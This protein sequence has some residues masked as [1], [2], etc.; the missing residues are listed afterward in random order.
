MPQAANLSINDGTAAVV[1]SPDSV[2]A[3]HVAYQNLAQP[4]LSLR[5]MAHLDRP[6]PTGNG[7]K[8]VRRSFRVNT[9]V[10]LTLADGTKVMKMVTV[11]V[12]EISPVDVPVAARTR[13]RTLAMNGL[14]NTDIVKVFDN[15][16]WI[17]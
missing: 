2:T 1:F 14:A 16:E 8:D 15:P 13:C 17:F 3:T 10:E 6:A 4:V 12:E 7:S 11:K 5:E 9:P